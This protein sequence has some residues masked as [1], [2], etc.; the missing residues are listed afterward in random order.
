VLPVVMLGITTG[1]AHAQGGA[2]PD[3]AMIRQRQ[4]ADSIARADSAPTAIIQA[5]RPVLTEVGMSHRWDGDS[6]LATG[7]VTLADF[8]DRIPGLATLRANWYMAPQI[9][10]YLGD[11]SRVRLFLDGIEQEPLDRRSG[12]VLDL[13][14]FPIATLEDLMIERGANEVRLHARTWRGPQRYSTYTRAD[15][16]TGDDQSNTF[17]GLLARRTRSGLAIQA[18]AQNRGT[19]DLRVGGDG[20]ATTL[21]GRVALVR[22]RWTMEANV[23][24]TRHQ[25]A[26]LSLF[27]SP[28]FSNVGE[29]LDAY[30]VRYR[31]AWLRFSYGDTRRGRW[32]QLVAAQRQATQYDP[33]QA[34][35]TTPIADSLRADTLTRSQQYVAT[36]GWTAGRVQLSATHRVRVGAGATTQHPSA[37]L[38]YESPRAALSLLAERTPWDEVTRAEATG[39][40]MLTPR[41]AVSGAVAASNAGLRPLVPDTSRDSDVLSLPAGRAARAELGVKIRDVWIQGGVIVRDS[42]ALVPPRILGA[43][44]VPVEEGRITGATAVIIG[45]LARGFSTH[46]SAVRWLGDLSAYRQ[47]QQARAEL[48]WTYRFRGDGRSNGGFVFRLAGVLEHRGELLMPVREGT[49]VVGR[50]ALQSNNVNVMAELKIRDLSA[51]FQIRNLTGSAYATVPGLLMPRALTIY[52]VR[53]AFWN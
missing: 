7:A 50:A 32:V 42:A 22:E 37:R 35:S 15:V 24:S 23:L 13:S 14:V 25:R 43:D 46:I 49:S 36:A 11:V 9:G 12:G 4:R 28:E 20:D 19:T 39:R 47:Q 48:A 3:S 45:P 27:P 40:V 30:A 21:M 31:D 44:W 33:E 2:I 6:L 5:P 10:A 53:W 26:S 34:N 52:G 29:P 17:R 41:L 8:L 18:L 51:S 16:T 38:G 1:F